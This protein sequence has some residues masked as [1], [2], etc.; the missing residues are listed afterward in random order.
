M[1]VEE[2][3]RKKPRWEGKGSKSKSKG[4]SK[5]KGKGW[6]KGSSGSAAPAEP[7]YPPTGRE[8]VVHTKKAEQEKAQSVFA[9]AQAMGKCEMIIR[10]AARVARQAAEAFEAEAHNMANAS[11]DL[12]KAQGVKVDQVNR[13]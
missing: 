4:K 3:E 2:P 13:F 9:M 12:C 5:G 1:E 7:A 11:N 10:A 6:G 8:L